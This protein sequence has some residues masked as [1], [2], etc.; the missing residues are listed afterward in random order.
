[1]T[2]YNAY[3]AQ[4]PNQAYTR[5]LSEQGGDRASSPVRRMLEARGRRQAALAPLYGYG[6][7]QE[8]GGQ[9]KD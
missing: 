3:Q 4:E 8:I 7:G 2:N 1:M 9:G 6:I 5:W